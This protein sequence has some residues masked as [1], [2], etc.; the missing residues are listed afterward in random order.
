MGE[1]CF[2]S[3]A[4]ND[5]L[6]IYS[7][8]RPMICIQC[9][10]SKNSSVLQDKQ[11]ARC[12]CC[13]ENGVNSDCPQVCTSETSA[14]CT[15]DEGND[16]Y[17]MCRTVG[18]GTFPP[19]PAPTEDMLSASPT[20][21]TTVDVFSPSPTVDVLDP[22]PKGIKNVCVSTDES[23]TRQ[24]KGDRC[25]CCGLEDGRLIIGPDNCPVEDA[26]DTLLLRHRVRDHAA[27]GQIEIRLPN[28]Q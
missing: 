22:L 6:S 5:R 28:S 9:V 1:T 8:V 4:F 14:E 27:R 12:E 25:G 23:L 20:V 24:L 11:G 15:D 16:G 17:Y 21:S 18:R 10:D 26:V 2:I 3:S 13:D 19:S 7:C